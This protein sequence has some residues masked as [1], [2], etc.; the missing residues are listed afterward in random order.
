MM[1][2]K[3]HLKRLNKLFLFVLAAIIFAACGEE[4]KESGYV[5]RVNNSYL[6]N[7]EF[8]QIIDTGLAGQIQKNEVIRNWI[9]REILFQ[10]AE[11]H[12]I[13]QQN[14]FKGLLKKSEK[15]LAGALL[16]N[17][18]IK[19]G[20]IIIT[21]RKLR[22]YFENNSNDFKVTSDSY[23]LNVIHFSDLDKA[24]EFRSLLLDNRWQNAMN[25]F[26][27]DSTVISSKDSVL[28]QEQDIYSIQVL[29][30]VKRLYPPEISIVISEREGYYTV[31]Q[32]L[33]K[34][35]ADS[36]P[37]FDVIRLEVE[38]RYLA[39]KRKEFLEAYINELYSTNDIEIIN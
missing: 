28:L 38:K 33:D 2:L 13:L 9:N 23:L 10:E 22:N 8:A 31:V 4:K 11:K 18:Q 12:G 37:S 34:Y 32:I 17:K 6:T 26:Y 14:D 16:L 30:V 3:W 21:P 25:Y 29:R 19:N 36:L 5:A 1:N 20:N 15:E 7:D 35:P 27:G 39:E 24:V